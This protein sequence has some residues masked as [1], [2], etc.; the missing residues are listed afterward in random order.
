ME[1]LEQFKVLEGIYNSEAKK[2]RSK[3]TKEEMEI[4]Y[5]ELGVLRRNIENIKEA[6]RSGYVGTKEGYRKA[7][8]VDMKDSELFNPQKAGQRAAGA[9]VVLYIAYLYLFIPVCERITRIGN[10]Y[11]WLY[12]SVIGLL[13]CGCICVQALAFLSPLLTCM[14]QSHFPSPS[15]LHQLTYQST[16]PL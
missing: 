5:S 10:I 12:L 11:C 16:P 6:Q 3:Y 15:T 4:R 13:Y 1:L 14:S 9:C 7:H 2:K 8:L